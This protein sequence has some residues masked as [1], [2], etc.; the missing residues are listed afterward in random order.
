MNQTEYIG[1]MLCPEARLLGTDPPPKARWRDF[2]ATT[3]SLDSW[4][5]VSVSNE[6]AVQTVCGLLPH[7]WA[8]VD[9]SPSLF[10]LFDD[11]KLTLTQTR[12]TRKVSTCAYD[13]SG[14]MLE[15][16]FG[17][18]LHQTDLEWYCS[19]PKVCGSGLPTAWTFDVLEDLVAPYGLGISEIWAR[20]GIFLPD[21]HLPWQSALGCNPL[22]LSDPCATDEAYLAQTGLESGEFFFHR[23]ETAPKG[24]VVFSPGRDGGPD[25]HAVYVPFR[26]RPPEDWSFALRFLP[27][28]R[29][30][31]RHPVATLGQDFEPVFEDRFS[32]DFWRSKI[33]DRTVSEIVFPNRCHP[34]SPGWTG[35]F[36]EPVEQNFRVR[37]DAGCPSRSYLEDAYGTFPDELDDG[38]FD[39]GYGTWSLSAERAEAPSP[40]KPD[41]FEHPGILPNLEEGIR[42]GGT[43]LDLYASYLRKVEGVSS[44]QEVFEMCRRA[45]RDLDLPHIAAQKAEFERGVYRGFGEEV[46]SNLREIFQLRTVGPL[47]DTFLEESV[48]AALSQF[49]LEPLERDPLE[50]F[51]LFYRFLQIEELAPEDALAASFALSG[52]AFRLSEIQNYALSDGK[53]LPGVG[54]FL[55]EAFDLLGSA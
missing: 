37:E 14:D 48:L 23:T 30:V 54:D 13:A 31:R 39:S 29:C 10:L 46:S 55:E 41:P 45:L 47:S 9:G 35:S 18:N 26:G 21:E 20:K 1:K 42:E 3:P 44:E 36:R 25:G 4:H 49:R 8:E 15:N 2:Y 40:P 27:R 34:S 50:A 38:L 6:S 12:R 11:G 33:G 43:V 51:G 5:R 28:E 53:V 7:V 52:K 17:I 24:A 16:L 32:V 22:S 19:H